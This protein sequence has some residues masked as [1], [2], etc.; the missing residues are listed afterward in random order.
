MTDGGMSHGG[1]SHDSMNQSDNAAMDHNG[2][3]DE[4]PGH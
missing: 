2:Q 1:M 3:G 4:H